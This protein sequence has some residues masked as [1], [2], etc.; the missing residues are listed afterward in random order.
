[1]SPVPDGNSGRFLMSLKT[2]V[3]PVSAYHN[4]RI[5]GVLTKEL[6]V[7]EEGD[8]FFIAAGGVEHPSPFP[9]ISIDL[10]DAK[11][12]L[13]ASIRDNL[14]DSLATGLTEKRDDDSLSI[15]DSGGKE[16]F[17]YYVKRYQN[18]YVTE[19]RGEFYTRKGEPVIL[20]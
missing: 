5:N 7:G 13:I 6:L 11:G 17:A 2:T 18:V 12:A 10:F 20:P 4:Y 19:I 16:I 1:M 8:G 3:T 15:I 14:T 9:R